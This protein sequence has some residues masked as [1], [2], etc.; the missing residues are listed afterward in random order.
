MTHSPIRSATIVLV[1]MTCWSFPANALHSSC[2]Q[3]N[4]T[5]CIIQC[6]NMASDR[7]KRGPTYRCLRQCKRFCPD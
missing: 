2:P 3:G 6:N 1:F 4:F 7:Y 5:N